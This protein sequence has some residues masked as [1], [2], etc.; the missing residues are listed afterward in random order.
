MELRARL[1]TGQ[2][3][4]VSLRPRSSGPF[5]NRM[6]ITQQK[7]IKVAGAIA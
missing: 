2:G 7:A 5:G 1:P 3:A 4:V 6:G